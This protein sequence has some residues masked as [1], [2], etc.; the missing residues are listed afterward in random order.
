MNQDVRTPRR[1]V[2][3]SAN[4]QNGVKRPLPPVSQP[5][6]LSKRHTLWRSKWFIVSAAAMAVIAVAGSIWLWVSFTD[7]SKSKTLSG[8]AKEYQAKLPELKKAVAKNPKSA[9]AHKDYAVALYA[10]GDFSAARDQ[11]EQVVK[12]DDKDAV[13]FNN[14]GNTYRD[15]GRYDDAVQAYQKSLALAP[16]SINTYANLA[17][18]QLY[19]LNKS[20]DAIA[21]YRSGLKQLPDNP[22]LQ[23]LLAI[24]YEQAD[25]PDKAAATYK[26]ILSHDPKNKA[27]KAGLERLDT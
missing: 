2:S 11:Y 14:L 1:N 8:V 13:A 20:D 7:G 23:L 19:S 27:A 26:D 3:V 18:V 9:T 12:L 17:N 5:P 25:Q 22:E 10:T 6:H 21:T 16:K 4:R 24:A 15:L